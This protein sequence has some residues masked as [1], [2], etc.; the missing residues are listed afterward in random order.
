MGPPPDTKGK[1]YHEDTSKETKMT[2]YF[3]DV[4]YLLNDGSLKTSHCDGPR[5]NKPIT[6]Y[7]LGIVFFIPAAR[8]FDPI[9]E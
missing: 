6:M 8:D 3:I 9:K 2:N 5:R 1:F 4:S 7:D